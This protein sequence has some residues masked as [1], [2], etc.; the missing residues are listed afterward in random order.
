MQACAG[1]NERRRLFFRRTALND[2]AVEINFDCTQENDTYENLFEHLRDSM[3]STV[4]HQID[5]D[6]CV[7]N[8]Y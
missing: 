2:A 1:R 8:S 5:L 4:L 7:I 6:G 3:L